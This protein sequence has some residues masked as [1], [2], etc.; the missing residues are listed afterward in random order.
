MVNNKRYKGIEHIT[1]EDKE[2]V[3]L[4]YNRWKV[5]RHNPNREDIKLLF[6]K[7]HEYVYKSPS[8][9]ACPSCVQ[10]IYDYWHSVVAEW[11]LLDQT[12]QPVTNN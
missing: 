11:Y 7:Y 3:K 10:F 12:N 9:M 1:A 6:A 4:S 5:N 2:Q 8:D